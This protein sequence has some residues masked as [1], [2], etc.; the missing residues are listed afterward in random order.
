L[1]KSKGGSIQR[2]HYDAAGFENASSHFGLRTFITEPAIK[3]VSL[4]V[5]AE[6]AGHSSIH[7]T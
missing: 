1:W 4:R 2:K 5:L 7:S 3:G 6:L